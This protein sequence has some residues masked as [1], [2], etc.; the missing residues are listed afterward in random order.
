[1]ILKQTGVLKQLSLTSYPEASL[2]DIAPIDLKLW[3][4]NET[5]T[6]ERF[7]V[8]MTSTYQYITNEVF[9][10]NSKV[11]PIINS[12]ALSIEVMALNEEYDI[13]MPEEA[14]VALDNLEKEHSDQEK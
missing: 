3:I 9:G 6:I 14:K 12:C 2:K 7:E 13:G 8:D 10:E 5:I 11:N 4:N 1:M